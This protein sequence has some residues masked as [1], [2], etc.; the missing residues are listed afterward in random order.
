MAR[1]ALLRNILAFLG[2]SLVFLSGAFHE[3]THLER[4]SEYS[5]Y[6]VKTSTKDNRYCA[7][8]FDA[9]DKPGDYYGKE[10]SNLFDV[11]RT[12]IVTYGSGMNVHKE[13]DVKL[14]DYSDS[15]LSLFFVGAIGSLALKDDEGEIIGWRHYQYNINTMFSDPMYNGT[16]F[17]KKHAPVVYLSQQQADKILESRNIFKENG[18]YTKENYQSL[19]KTEIKLTI[20]G[21]ECSYYIWN[22]FYNDGFYCRGLKDILGEFVLTSYYQPTKHD[23]RQIHKSMYYFNEYAYY[24]QYLMKYLNNRYLGESLSPSIVKNNITKE[25]DYDFL[26]SFFQNENISSGHWIYTSLTI[27]AVLIIGASILIL[28]KSSKDNFLFASISLLTL[29]LPYVIFKSIYVLTNDTLFFSQSACKINVLL[30][31]LYAL[32]YLYKMLAKQKLVYNNG[33]SKYDEIEI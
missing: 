12:G 20:E 4:I 5:S 11:F 10:L 13:L 19:I 33:C 28:F 30:V 26:L 21:D 29:P 25:V 22:I 6:V 15:N 9:P 24:N 18:G 1:K 8:S 16:E 32:L 3:N 14:L 7:I 31:V 2:L 23:L 17:D 27:I